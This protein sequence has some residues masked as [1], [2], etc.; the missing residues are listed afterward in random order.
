M[1]RFMLVVFTFVL[2]AASAF[3]WQSYQQEDDTIEVGQTEAELVTQRTQPERNA[4]IPALPKSTFLPSAHS[5][6]EKPKLKFESTEG[7]LETNS[8]S[9]EIV[10][11]DGNAP[12][13]GCV[14]HVLQLSIV[15]D[16]KSRTALMQDMI[17]FLADQGK[18][19]AVPES[20]KLLIP[21]PEEDLILGAHSKSGFAFAMVKVNGESPVKLQLKPIIHLRARVLD[22]HGTP[23]PDANVSFGVRHVGPN[24]RTAMQEIF[25]RKTN[26]QGIAHIEAI[27]DVI[28][29]MKDEGVPYLGLQ[30]VADP[31]VAVQIDFEKPPTEVV[32]L[33]MPKMGLLTVIVR[34]LDGN[35]TNNTL[36]IVIDVDDGDD[37]EEKN[38]REGGLLTKVFEGG[39]IKLPYIACGLKLKIRVESVI[40]KS[41]APL[42]KTINGPLSAGDNV[43]VE[44]QFAE[45]FP[46]VSGRLL[47]PDGKPL[48]NKNVYVAWK[49]RVDGQ[50]KMRG[51]NLKTDGEGRYHMALRDKFAQ[52]AEYR[53]IVFEVKPTKTQK[54]IS[55]QHKLP[56]AAHAVHSQDLEDIQLE[57]TPPLVSG[58][59][60]DRK[61]NLVKGA[62]VRII[63]ASDDRQEKR[64]FKT[65]FVGKLLTSDTGEFT[66]NGICNE[67]E[68]C[69]SL[70]AEGFLSTQVKVK[71]GARGVRITMDE[72]CFLTGTLAL[73]EKLPLS[74]MKGSLES[75]DGEFRRQIRLR[76]KP[77]FK[78]R[79][80][81]P[82]KYK[83]SFMSKLCGTAPIWESE[84]IDLTSGET[85]DFGTI[86]VRF[87]AVAVKFILRAPKFNRFETV[88]IIRSR[89]PQSGKRLSEHYLNEESQEFLLPVDGCD[90]SVV[91]HD[92]REKFFTNVHKGTI[93]LELSRGYPI[94][95]NIKN[96]EVLPEG[97]SIGVLLRKGDEWVRAFMPGH[98]K[99]DKDTHYIEV[100]GD[101]TIKG[102]VVSQN[103]RATLPTE[104]GRVDILGTDD[105]Q[106]I[107]IQLDPEEVKKAIAEMNE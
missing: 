81:P 82:G 12:G 16:L 39:T 42:R 17:S 32:D 19:H 83:V 80:L 41:F 43:D 55:A 46:T 90:L 29:R 69:V 50:P 34:D 102:F 26:S 25:V 56:I 15:Q 70:K 2:G 6:P 100:K 53:Y 87:D 31:M 103:D 63:S 60:F 5:E 35:V 86:K 67:D 49:T 52:G 84:L 1:N 54:S 22:E 40:G 88:A 76:K 107:D 62:M 61:G 38:R 8:L 95:F 4:T 96:P 97:M 101:Y 20:G 78:S 13:A 89:D 91:M 48:K 73:P 92:Y 68:F 94:K 64:K 104:L 9:V 72:A 24:A 71:K 30:C 75:A 33:Q 45:A 36:G 85:F 59:V 79:P 7:L 51:W 99:I 74:S 21:Y 47:G 93:E 3:L 18:H 66:A 106:T 10:D 11:Q 14:L 65:E 105:L 37:D 23:V 27:H 77:A 28:A 57:L 44:F 98:G 58:V